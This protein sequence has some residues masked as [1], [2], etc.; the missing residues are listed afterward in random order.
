MILNNLFEKFIFSKRFHE[1]RIVKD[2]DIFFWTSLYSIDYYVYFRLQRAK[3]LS[4]FYSLYKEYKKIAT[5]THT[6]I[7][8]T[9][10]FR[11]NGVEEYAR[12]IESERSDSRCRDFAF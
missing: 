10:K 11:V 9:A 7:S 6:L 3:E 2:F 8:V 1:C 4:N 5:R 12:G